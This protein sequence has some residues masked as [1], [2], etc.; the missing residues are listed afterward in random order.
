[1]QVECHNCEHKVDLIVK[2]TGPVACPNCIG[3][4]YAKGDGGGVMHK[5]GKPTEAVAW[6]GASGRW[7]KWHATDADGSFT[8]CGQV[9]V[10]MQGDGSP[11]SGE[12]SHVTCQRCRRAMQST[13]GVK[14]TDVV[15]RTKLETRSTK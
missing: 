14:P 11:R 12:L 5:H 6:M 9:V 2:P 4:M 10:L 1:M 3:V 8:L 13:K 7:G 15:I